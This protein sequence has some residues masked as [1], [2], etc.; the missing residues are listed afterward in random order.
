MEIEEEANEEAL[1][2]FEKR[3]LDNAH[4][5]PT[6]LHFPGGRLTTGVSVKPC[7][8]ACF[9]CFQDP[10]NTFGFGYMANHFRVQTPATITEGEKKM[11]GFLYLTLHLTR[12]LKVICL[13]SFP[14]NRPKQGKPPVK[15]RH[16]IYWV[17]F[18]HF[19]PSLAFD[20]SRNEDNDVNGMLE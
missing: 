8:P 10:N 11:W 9:L 5:R 15:D 20:G 18:L 13:K 2:V 14:N 1:K 12:T 7:E 16:N 6:Q 4:I 3:Q 17:S 19:C